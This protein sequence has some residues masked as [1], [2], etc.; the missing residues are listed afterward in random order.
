MT[1]QGQGSTLVKNIKKDNKKIFEESYITL[2]DTLDDKVTFANIVSII[3]R[4]IEIV[5]N[6]KELTGLDK[7]LLVVKLI[8]TLIEKHEDDEELKKSLIDLLNTVGVTVIDT[9]IYASKGKLAI[10][11]KKYFA[12]F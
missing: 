10:N 3:T 7:K 11:L 1:N 8:T 9:I 2:L 6:Y 4:S 5:D 12:C